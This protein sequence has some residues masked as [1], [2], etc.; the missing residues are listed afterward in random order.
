ML[1]DRHF[2]ALYGT[3][4][5]TA[6]VKDKEVV[7]SCWSFLSFIMYE[8]LKEHLAMTIHVPHRKKMYLAHSKALDQFQG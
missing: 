1:L 8:Q 6:I 5:K 3:N 4:I 2:C 7:M